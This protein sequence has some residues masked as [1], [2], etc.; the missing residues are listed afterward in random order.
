MGP[1]PAARA[2]WSN[3]TQTTARMRSESICPRREV[4]G[5]AA[6]AELG[7]VAGVSR[8]A[9]FAVCCT[10]GSDVGSP[11]HVESPIGFFETLELPIARKPATRR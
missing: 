1:E 3:S 8:K 4:A 10:S 9:A 5:A 6:G 7:I 11:T 2:K